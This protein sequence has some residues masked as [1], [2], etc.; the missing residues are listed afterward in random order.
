MYRQGL[1]PLSTRQVDRYGYLLR[2]LSRV[3]LSVS[4]C[5]NLKEL[6]HIRITVAPA[7]DTL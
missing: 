4:A 5:T 2:M 6:D 7:A 3:T 1:E